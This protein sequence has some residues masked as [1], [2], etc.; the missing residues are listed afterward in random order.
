[1]AFVRTDLALSSASQN[2]AKGPR[3]WQYTTTDATATVDSAG[4]FNDAA[5]LLTV[6]DIIEAITSSGGTPS[7]DSYHVNANDG[8]TVD[9]ADTVALDSASDTD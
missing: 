4:Y 3:R 6:G 8:S 5:D 2:S 9:V 1:M 7:Y